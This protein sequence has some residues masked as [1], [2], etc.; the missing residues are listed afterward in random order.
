MGR[1][2]G[3]RLNMATGFALACVTM[4]AV[5]PVARAHYF[6]LLAPAVLLVPLWLDRH[7][8]PGAGVVMAAIPPVLSILHYVL[9]PY[10]G[11]VGLLGLGIT[12]WLMAAMVLLAR[13]DWAA[14][15]AASLG[16]APASNSVLPL[17][18][19]A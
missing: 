9:L 5:S 6:L 11:R 8:R 3:N 19:A 4:L 7:G 13:A 12:A 18:R 1:E 10:A 14:I 17:N 15:R 2:A 16:D